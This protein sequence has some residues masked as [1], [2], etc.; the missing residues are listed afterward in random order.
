MFALRI[1]VKRKYIEEI[2]K[3]GATLVLHGFDGLP[4]PV[5]CV[6]DIGDEN[7][8]EVTLGSAYS[9][10]DSSSYKPQYSSIA[11]DSPEL[12]DIKASVSTCHTWLHRASEAASQGDMENAM[13]WISAVKHRLMHYE[14]VL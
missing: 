14:T 5:A 2:G 13:Y 12:E 4:L 6:E 9:F 10:I 11:T 3:H 8:L 7:H 1:L